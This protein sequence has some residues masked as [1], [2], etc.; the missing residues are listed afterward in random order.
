MRISTGRH[1]DLVIWGY[2]SMRSAG[3]VNPQVPVSG[4][5]TRTKRRRPPQTTISSRAERARGTRRMPGRST[6]LRTR[7]QL[8]VHVKYSMKKKS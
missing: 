2:K 8:T 7:T 1:P 5:R 4:Q 3:I 6:R